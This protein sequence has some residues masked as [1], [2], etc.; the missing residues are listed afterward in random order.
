MR[1]AVD[2]LSVVALLVSVHYRAIS[3]I[4]VS[5]TFLAPTEQLAA[6]A[7]LLLLTDVN[8]QSTAQGGNFFGAEFI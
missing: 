7:V 1:I 6:V 3:F 4:S 8:I 2:E 5:L